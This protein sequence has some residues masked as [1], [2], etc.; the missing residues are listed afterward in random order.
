MVLERGLVQLVVAKRSDQRDE[1]TFEHRF[2]PECGV[3]PLHDNPGQRPLQ[4][5]SRV[6][7]TGF[8]QRDPRQACWG[9]WKEV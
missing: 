2:L 4:Q 5:R 8:A 1:R 6:V 7:N 3:L 9:C